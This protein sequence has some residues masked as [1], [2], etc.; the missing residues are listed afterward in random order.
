M[1]F[2]PAAA[3]NIFQNLFGNG[4]LDG[5]A[6]IGS[7]SAYKNARLLQIA[8]GSFTFLANANIEFYA[9]LTSGAIVMMNNAGTASLVSTATLTNNGTLMIHANASVASNAIQFSPGIFATSKLENSGTIII[10]GPYLSTTGCIN[11]AGT[12]ATSYAVIDNLSGGML[13]AT[14]TYGTSITTGDT[15]KNSLIV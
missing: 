13:S 3:K 14:N 15:T 1:T 9:G 12:D 2:I 11:C 8:A 5:T 6:V 10:D 4:Q 7:A